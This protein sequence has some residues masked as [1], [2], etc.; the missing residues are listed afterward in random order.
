MP[1]SEP[2]TPGEVAR[3]LTT[4][5]ETVTGIDAKLDKRPTWADLD[6]V[7]KS[8]TEAHNTDVRA[9]SE[10]HAA[11]VRALERR[12]D[13]AAEDLDERVIELQQWQTWAVR[14]VLGAVI[15]AVLGLVIIEQPV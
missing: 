9:L 4:I 2:M 15:L 3:T 14:L 10:T 13:T 6:R 8:H 12:I 5:R 1:D 11:D 7:L